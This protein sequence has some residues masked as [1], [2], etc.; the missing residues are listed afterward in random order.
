MLVVNNKNNRV[1]AMDLFERFIDRK[2]YIYLYN[3]LS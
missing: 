3:R 2:F 1:F